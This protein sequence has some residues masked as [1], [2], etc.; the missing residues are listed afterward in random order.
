[1]YF[2]GSYDD[3]DSWDHK[4]KADGIPDILNEAKVGTDYL[5]K[6]V[7]SPTQIV[8][9]IGNAPSDHGSPLLKA[10]TIIP[11]GSI[12]GKSRL[13]AD[14]ADAPAWYSAAL[15]LM[16]K[17]YKSYDAAYS[18]TCL[19]KAKDAFTFCTNH[20]KGV[21]LSGRSEQRRTALLFRNHLVR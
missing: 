10:G 12:T 16:S 18:A 1:M 17:L 21:Q 15:A 6:A 9:D 5:I 3:L 7:V 11:T 2:R 20:K 13:W 19:Q 8:L 14:G 4:G